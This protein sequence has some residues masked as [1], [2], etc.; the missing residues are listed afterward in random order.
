MAADRNLLFGLFALQNGLIDQD[1]LINAFRAWTRDKSQSIASLLSSRGDLDADQR[2]AVEA[3]LALHLKKHDNDTERS[4]AA[5]VA[6]DSTRERLNQLGDPDVE[7]SVT[8]VCSRSDGDGV[9]GR[10]FSLGSVTSEGQRFRVLRPHASGGLG[11]VF[12]ALDEELHREV[13]LKEILDKY[14]DD[15]GSRHASC[16]RPRLLADWSIPESSP[17]TDSAPTPEAVRITRCGSSGEIVSRKRSSGS[18]MTRRSRT[19]RAGGR[20]N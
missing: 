6:G 11:A 16:S 13:A 14:A 3:L 15:P 10:S 8:Y 5:L 18:T 12:V 9:S 20:W 2:T 7:A 4:L 17:F 19:T 1:Q